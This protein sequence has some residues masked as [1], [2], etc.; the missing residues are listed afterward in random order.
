MVL[1]TGLIRD[2]KD[3]GL[4]TERL[5]PE[6]LLQVIEQVHGNNSLKFYSSLDSGIPNS[7]HYFLAL[8]LLKGHCVFTT[9]VDTLIEKACENIGI[10]CTP[11]FY[12]K[13]Y[14]DFL[15]KQPI[16]FS[17]QLF[18]LHGSIEPNKVG[19]S[20]YKSIRF[21][22]N[23]VGLGLREYTRK[24]LST[25]L[26]ERD[27]IFLGYSGNDHFSVHPELLNDRFRPKNILVQVST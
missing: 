11:I 10:E 17:S 24:T 27:F 2:N 14:R 9:N 8:A 1:P 7:N 13:H 25:C 16:D 21:T 12:E 5:R 3:V 15:N 6:V 22:L 20:K 26:K 4:I 19:L 18:K 23:R